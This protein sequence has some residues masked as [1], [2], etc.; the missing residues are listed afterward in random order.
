MV[1]EH[2]LEDSHE[3][4]DSFGMSN[5]LHAQDNVH[6]FFIWTDKSAINRIFFHNPPEVVFYRFLI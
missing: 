6:D 1:K 4:S 2:D 5:Y 3:E